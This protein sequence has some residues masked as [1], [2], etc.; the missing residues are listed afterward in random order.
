MTANGRVRTMDTIKSRLDYLHGTLDMSWR[1]IADTGEF[2]GIAPGT[3]CSIAN[4]REPKSAHL[5]HALGLPP[6]PVP[7]LPCPECGQLHE[8]LATCPDQLQKARRLPR[9]HRLHYECGRGESGRKREAQ[10]RAEMQAM[11]VENLTQLVDVLLTERKVRL[12]I[13]P[14]CGNNSCM[15]DGVHGLWCPECGASYLLE[16]K[17]AND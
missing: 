3:L 13:C 11:A 12:G 9:R 1:E 7:V 16:R 5:R 8:Q 14:D 15:A 6:K 10:L 17:R 4:G 2:S